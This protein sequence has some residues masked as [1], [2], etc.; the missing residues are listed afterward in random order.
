MTWSGLGSQRVSIPALGSLQ[1]TDVTAS[2]FFSSGHCASS[3]CA[4]VSQKEVVSGAVFFVPGRVIRKVWSQVLRED[5]VQ[6][7]FG[8]QTRTTCA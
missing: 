6:V 7:S 4:F 2:F 1:F 3:S 5:T 8:L